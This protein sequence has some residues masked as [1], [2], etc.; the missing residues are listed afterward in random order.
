MVT[1][2]TVRSIGHLFGF[3]HCHREILHEPR[4]TPPIVEGH[5]RWAQGLQVS[6]DSLCCDLPAQECHPDKSHT[7]EVDGCNKDLYPLGA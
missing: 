1:P 4:R 2:L 5:Q 7:S 6:V 3:I